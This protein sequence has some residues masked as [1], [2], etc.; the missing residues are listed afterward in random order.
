M[1]ELTYE[2]V[3]EA[4]LVAVPEF[5][6]E[7]EQHHSDYE[8]EVLP[9][10]LFGDLT[11]FVLAARDRGDHALVDRCLVF[12]EE[13][14]R[15]PR[16][17]LSN[18]A[19]VSFVE[20]VAPWQPEMRSFIKTWPKELKRV[21]ARQGWG[22]PPNEYVPSPPDID[23]YVRLESRDRVVV[24]SFLD[25]HMTTWRQDAAWYDAEP[26][27]E[28]FARADA[29]PAAAFAR[30]GEPTM[31]GLSKVIVAFGTD[32]SMVFGLSI[33]GDFNPDAEE[34]AT[35]LVDDLMARYGASEGAAIWEHPPPLDQEQ[36]AELDKLGGL[37]VA[38]RQT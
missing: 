18:L 21:A 11:R 29:D 31:P 19:A 33:H 9:H 34:Q 22:R 2:T 27:A 35:A 30:Y 38:R 20:N 23:V 1:S 24:E 26:V 14:A 36:W 15:S 6:A 16:Q 37:V 7:L 13:V 25:R 28:A 12:L 17:R 32:G 8:G 4:L 5:R 10:L 3:H